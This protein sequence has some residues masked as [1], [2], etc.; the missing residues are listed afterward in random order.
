[1]R[2]F[3]W[4]QGMDGE[5]ESDGRND[6]EMTFYIFTPGYC[7]CPRWC[8]LEQG[9]VGNHSAFKIYVLCVLR[10][11]L[12]PSSGSLVS[13]GS[14]LS[15]ASAWKRLWLDLPSLFCLALLVCVFVVKVWHDMTWNNMTL[16]S[17]IYPL[18]PE[19]PICGE[20]FSPWPR[21]LVTAITCHLHHK[22]T[23]TSSILGI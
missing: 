3:L 2:N 21:Y 5:G 19:P 23:E 17:F 12:K 8:F 22:I 16:W 6:F 14:P 1:M 4:S 7:C 11:L 15:P 9:V 10:E 18:L 20:G 13:A